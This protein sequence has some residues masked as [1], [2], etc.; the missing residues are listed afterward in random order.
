[1]RRL[2][3]LGLILFA[4]AVAGCA[5]TPP[6][7]QPSFGLGG[8]G[9]AAGG[10]SAGIAGLGGVDGGAGSAG[11]L[12]GGPA[13]GSGGDDAGVDAP[14]AGGAGGNGGAG[15]GG[16]T[17]GSGAAGAAGSSQI[18]PP[19][20]I[21]L[22]ALNSDSNTTSLSILSTAGGL[23][24]ADCVDSSTGSGGGASK[25][26]SGDAVL[27]SQPQR[28][29]E[30]VIVDRGYGVL[31]FVDP[32]VCTI[33]RQQSIPGGGK[34]NPTDVVILADAKAYVA[35]YAQNLAATD[36]T[37]VGNDVLVMNPMTGA[38]IGRIDLDVYA[39]AVSGAT[40]LVR[41]DRAL[42]ADGR[43]VVSLD[44]NDA[45]STIY[46]EGKLVLIDPATD[47][48]VADVAL[49][50]LY[51]CEGLTYFEA[52]RTLLVSCGGALGAQ[53][54]PVESGIAVVD[55]GGP[56]PILVRSISAVA[57]DDRPLD[58]ASVVVLPP[59]AG[60]TRAFAVT[61]DP[62][63]IEPDALFAFDY[64]LGTSTKLATADAHAFGRAA[65]E[66]GLLLV[67]DSSASAPQIRLYDVSGSPR[68]TTGFA[69]DPLT[70]LQPQE[71][72]AY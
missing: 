62:N 67:P 43:V 58:T 1:M 66:P 27:P 5:D 59:A 22:V 55:L 8:S 37:L 51:D 44:E 28:G 41:P 6:T 56:S 45:T 33:A 54:G 35:R 25:T 46:G 32:G 53:D 24:Q 42:I 7:G 70:G 21:G 40:I 4:G 60:G 23:L 29:G 17:G 50:G 31:T 3:C 9:G 34:T 30:I 64:V 16:A 10:G 2:F 61:V 69:S 20:A 14:N 65:G 49:S 18:A 71:V 39:S 47:R 11:G 19:A 52:T 38:S 48:V 15:P 72:A 68:A 26:I 36:P 13:G 57:F 63:G 12:G